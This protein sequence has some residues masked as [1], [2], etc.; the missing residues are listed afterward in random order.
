MAQFLPGVDLFGLIAELFILA[1][2]VDLEPRLASVPPGT[3]VDVVLR[4]MWIGPNSS[5]ASTS[6]HGTSVLLD[7]V[8]PNTPSATVFQGRVEFRGN[9]VWICK[10]PSTVVMGHSAIRERDFQYM[11]ETC[12]GLGAVSTGFA[13]CGVVTSVYNDVNK[14]FTDWMKRNGKRAILGDINDIKVVQSMG[15]APGMFLSAGISCQPFSLLGDGR[16]QHDERSKSFTGT[17]KAGHLLQAQVILLEC[18][19]AAMTS[20]WI[21]AN[22]ASFANQTKFKVHQKIL[23]LHTY[24]V[25]KRTRW[26]CTISNPALQVQE[27]PDIPPMIFNPTCLHL[28]PK[29]M[30][31]TDQ[32]LQEIELSMHELRMFHGYPFL[33]KHLVDVM[34]TLPTATHSWGS[35]VVAC[36][37]GCR[38]AGFTT[39]RLEEKG[40]YGQLLPIG[41]EVTH[42]G[43]Q[44]RRCR[45][46]H[47]QEIAL[48][49]GL[50]PFHVGNHKGSCRLEV[51]GVGQMASPFQGAWV[52]SNVLQ[53][54]H[55]HAFPLKNFRAPMDIMQTMAMELLWARDKLLGISKHTPSNE[56]FAKAIQQ[57]GQVPALPAQVPADHIK[58]DQE[59]DKTHATQTKSCSAAHSM[60]EAGVGRNF[61]SD[62]TSHALTQMTA[63]D[64]HSFQQA[65]TAAFC[66]TEA[67]VGVQSNA[68]HDQIEPE[69]TA[70]EAG[71]ISKL[72]TKPGLTNSVSANQMQPSHLDA[73]AICP[74]ECEPR[75]QADHASTRAKCPTSGQ[76][77]KA[78]DITR[79]VHPMNTSV[80]AAFCASEAGQVDQALCNGLFPLKSD[81]VSQAGL[82][83]GSQ[84]EMSPLFVQSIGGD[85]RS[86]QAG[87]AAVCE[88]NSSSPNCLTNMHVP[89]TTH[90][91]GQ[92]T[93][94]K[95]E[96]RALPNAHGPSSAHGHRSLPTLFHATPLPRLGC[97][98][99]SHD[100]RTNPS[101]NPKDVGGST[102]CTSNQVCQ[103]GPT[104]NAMVGIAAPACGHRDELTRPNTAL[105]SQPLPL[106][107]PGCGGHA[108]ERDHPSTSQVCT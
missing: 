32:D 58:R 104:A 53:N 72:K 29:M 38:G 65:G 13:K 86:D 44:F 36:S 45:H 47:A 107:R 23:D 22:L 66:A 70:S 55:Q 71:W 73:A 87:P 37:C 108:V 4:P 102:T 3:I 69:P 20:E 50:N 80:E 52:L 56:I 88:P 90:E 57:W 79:P 68:K 11:R 60:S 82:M 7:V 91:L 101:E 5:L 95:P 85:S 89:H 1:M 81:V 9:R 100:Q 103:V 48:A 75:G 94:G 34:K 106:P 26:W 2:E 12:A 17:L 96:G 42:G 76:P 27:I 28:F 54:I 49:N 84:S 33:E 78:A 99:P 19:P 39:Q 93:H 18:T 25:S 59:V 67:G 41:G 83:V 97:G 43:Q 62:P 51:A 74:P 61:T 35:Q 77:S 10:M 40:L 8:L 24:W 6:I 30:D 105:P 46:L 21:Q 92:E 63:S 16:Q 15:Q 14:P 64:K 31:I 98:G